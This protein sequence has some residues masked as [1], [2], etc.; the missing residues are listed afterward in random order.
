MSSWKE[1]ITIHKR[2]V[3]SLVRGI[4][5]PSTQEFIKQNNHILNKRLSEDYCC[6]HQEYCCVFCD[7]PDE[8]FT[9][10]KGTSLG[11]IA[12]ITNKE[13]KYASHEEW[14]KLIQFLKVSKIFNSL[15]TNFCPLF[16]DKNI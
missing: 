5:S 3:R 8:I 16:N 15:K 1:N 14:V 12:L 11:Y 2:V 7:N 13:E 9:I 10:K 6:K 4:L